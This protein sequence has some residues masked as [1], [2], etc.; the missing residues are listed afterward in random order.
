MP[1]KKPIKP[2]R[3]MTHRQLTHW[4][5]ES[6]IQRFTLLGGVVVIVAILII[7]GTG[8][9]VNKYA[10]FRAVVLKA[11][12]AEFTQGYY[13]DALSYFGRKDYY[14]YQ[15]YGMSYSQYLQYTT[16][17]IAQE[18][19]RDAILKDAAAKLTPP[20]TVSDDEINKNIT[21]NKVTPVNQ[22]TRDAIYAQ[23]LDT[24]LSD[25]FGKQVPATAE[26]RAVLAMFLESDSQV[27]N[28]KA[29]LEGGATFGDLAGKMSLEGT[30]KSK[31]GDF[32][33]VPKGVLPANL[34]NRT[35][36]VLEDLVFA[37]ELAL[38]TPV[39]APDKDQSKTIGYWI[40]K[41]VQYQT[42]TP[43]PTP[44]AT[45]SP[46][47]TGTATP[48]AT[49]TP[50]PAQ[51]H[52]LAMLLASQE[53]AEQIKAQLENGADFFTLAKA[54]SQK[55]DINTNSGDLGFISKG[56]L[57]GAADAVL[58]PDDASQNLQPGTLTGPIA[59]TAQNT[60]GG[61]W[62]AEVTAIDPNKAVEGDNKTTLTNNLKSD[63]EDKAW[64]DSQSQLKNDLTQAQIDAALTEVVA[65][66]P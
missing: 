41:V 5:R 53:E 51:V 54:N 38:N 7:V 32:G 16:S 3:E 66:G 4:Q 27:A 63:W 14:I 19:Q 56:T 45:P 46:T 22:A 24:K 11:G 29:Q 20:V 10:P 60:K 26:Q 6:R 21:D 42:P 9:F 52:V 35:D 30:S 64:T 62:L 65:R 33:F 37:P 48:T 2:Q 23:L 15:Q 34:N 36:T 61:Y 49:P 58:F 18:V 25:Y 8:V 39:A 13:I 28:V 44:T 55:S 31:N 57:G 43:T 40:L 12:N 17:V 50:T 59:D 1:K 47:A